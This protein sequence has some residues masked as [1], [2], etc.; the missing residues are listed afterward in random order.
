MRGFS[1]SE[2]RDMSGL[3]LRHASTRVKRDCSTLKVRMVKPITHFINVLADFMDA[4]ASQ[5]PPK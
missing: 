4:N 2:E 1:A 3:E 5:I